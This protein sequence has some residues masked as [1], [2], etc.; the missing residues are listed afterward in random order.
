MATGI[1]I[2][3]AIGGVAATSK[4]IFFVCSKKPGQI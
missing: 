3:S 2:M 1:G 4:T